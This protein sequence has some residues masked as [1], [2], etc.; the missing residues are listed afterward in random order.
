MQLES[1]SEIDK[2]AFRHG[3]LNVLFTDLKMLEKS[4]MVVA[5]IRL[6]KKLYGSNTVE[7]KKNGHHLYRGFEGHQNLYL[8]LFKQCGVSLIDSHIIIEKDL[9]EGIIQSHY[10]Y[11]KSE[12]AGQGKSHRKSSEVDRIDFFNRFY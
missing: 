12:A 9:R 5:W 2:F 11:W 7:K 10:N 4:L 3:D 1:N 8:W 6:L